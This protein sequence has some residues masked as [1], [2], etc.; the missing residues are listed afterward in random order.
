MR[1]REERGAMY[2]ATKQAPA[3]RNGGISVKTAAHFK[4]VTVSKPFL[5]N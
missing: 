3:V 4:T 1:D 5:K 2:A